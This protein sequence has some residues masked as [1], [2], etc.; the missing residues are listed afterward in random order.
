[1]NNLC[2]NL[3]NFLFRIEKDERKTIF[4]PVLE[5]KGKLSIQNISLK[6]RVECAK[7][8]T[9]RGGLGADQAS[10]VLQLRELDVSLER[11]TLQVR[12]TGYGSDWLLNRAVSAF[13]NEITQIVEENLREQIMQQTKN[14]IDNL[15]AYFLVNP[16]MLLNLLGVTMD[17]L[18][19]NV[20]W[21]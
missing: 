2:L 10:P 7:E 4:D 14:A 18:E 12:E 17:D 16:E 15:N 3:E 8:R 11:V 9:Q 21:V 13:S 5:G 1:M 20:V 6:L 19:Q